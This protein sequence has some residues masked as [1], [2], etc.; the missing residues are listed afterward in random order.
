MNGSNASETLLDRNLIESNY[1][2]WI[3]VIREGG[4]Q[5][6]A[7]SLSKTRLLKTGADWIQL[8]CQDDFI[9]QIIQE[10]QEKLC[11]VFGELINRNVSI[12]T[13]VL[14][15]TNTPS[16]NDPYTLLM[17]LQ[18]ERPIVKSIVDMLGAELEY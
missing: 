2:A 3:D 1:S 4:H 12:K 15:R 13:K 9:A 6:L 18:Q 16:N 8:E 10:H 5:V 14:Q 11:V 7:L 17:Q